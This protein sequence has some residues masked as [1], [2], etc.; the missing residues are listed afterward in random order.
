MLHYANKLRAV[1]KSYQAGNRS[2]MTDP[3][4]RFGNGSTT[5]GAA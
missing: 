4:P 2:S 5:L 3:S 1:A